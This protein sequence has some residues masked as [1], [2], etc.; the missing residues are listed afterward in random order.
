MT[1]GELW[2][3][4]AQYPDDTELYIGYINGHSIEEEPFTLAQIT[5]L[6]GKVTIAFM[7]SDINIIN[8]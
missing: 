3:A 4:L 5:N 7:T 2:D 1:I 6:D 8:N